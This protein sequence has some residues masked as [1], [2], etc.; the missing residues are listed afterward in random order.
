MTIQ[1]PKSLLLKPA[2]F[3]LQIIE[4]CRIMRM[5]QGLATILKERITS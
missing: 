3:S 4:F 1:Q 2:E 5:V